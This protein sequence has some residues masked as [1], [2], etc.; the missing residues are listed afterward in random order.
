MAPLSKGDTV[1]VTGSTGFIGGWLVSK[2][3]EG[4]YV[5]RACVRDEASPK[6]DF[7]RAMPGFSIGQLSLHSCDINCRGAFDAA[8]SGC[9]GVL[10][11]AADADLPLE[12]RADGYPDTSR[13]LIDSINKAETVSRVIYTSSVA[14]LAGDSDLESFRARPV[15]CEERQSGLE[16]LNGYSLGKIRSENLF[17]EA[18]AASGRWDTF[19]VNPTDNLG[20]VLAAHHAEERAAWMPWQAIVARILAGREFPQ[21]FQYRPLWVV[22]VRD[23]AAAHLRLLECDGMR[24]GSRFLAFS[25]E[26]ICVEDI[27]DRL[28]AL[29]PELGLT[30]SRQPAAAGAADAGEAEAE[31]QAREIWA[32]CEV[33]NDKIRNEL[34]LTFR[35]LDDTLKECAESLLS[36]AGV[37]PKQKT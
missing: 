19:V 33:R 4:G 5:V 37:R 31:A 15:I 32:Q 12:M 28:V 30:P 36:I 13:F 9:Q 17:V 29:F 2:L 16:H 20:P 27:G 10:H 7:L 26:S 8:F 3:L 21:T 18:A 6:A 25:G 35:S 23:T 11:A 14:S 34:G 24:A 22:D 1:A